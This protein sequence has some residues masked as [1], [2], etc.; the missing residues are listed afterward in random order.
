M[1]SFLL[2]LQ[3]ATVRRGKLA[4]RPIHIQGVDPLRYIKE[5]LDW[6]S[7]REKR[8]RR[9]WS[10]VATFSCLVHVVPPLVT[11]LIHVSVALP[12]E[13]ADAFE[14]LCLAQRRFTDSMSR[15]WN[16]QGTVGP[17]EWQIWLLKGRRGCLQVLEAGEFVGGCSSPHMYRPRADPVCSAQKNGHLPCFDPSDLLL[18]AMGW[19]LA[20]VAVRAHRRVYARVYL[21]I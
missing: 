16:F 7:D 10:V 18:Y 15:L 1:S 5:Q 11:I 19:C 3:F 2:C 20:A 21:Y 13:A 4:N 6:R 12:P 9:K 8:D 17:V 14:H